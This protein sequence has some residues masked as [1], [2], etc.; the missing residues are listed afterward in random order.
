MRLT[1]ST[2]GF[3]YRSDFCQHLHRL[4]RWLP[5]KSYSCIVATL[6]LAFANKSLRQL[7]ESEAKANRNLGVRMAEK[8]RRRLADLRAATCANDLIAGNP[9]E[10]DSTGSQQIAVN[11]CEGSRI[12]FCA[13]HNTIPLL[14][15]GGV[16]W[17]KVSRI[18]ILRIESD[19][20]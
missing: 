5:S 1:I 17:S 2:D 7:C 3:R 6:E 9:Y 14:E 11:L 12:V 16:D 4:P 19:H 20:D 8:L 18:K 15:S 10:L 13:N